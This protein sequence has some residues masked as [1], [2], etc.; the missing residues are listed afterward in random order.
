MKVE[1][2]LLRPLRC[3]GGQEHEWQGFLS[4][5]KTHNKVYYIQGWNNNV[6]EPPFDRKSIYP[7]DMAHLVITRERTSLRAKLKEKHFYCR[8]LSLDQHD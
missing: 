1:K 4:C 2:V 5:C 3:F 7:P 8:Y 6:Q